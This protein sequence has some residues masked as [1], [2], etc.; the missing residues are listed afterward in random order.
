MHLW[1]RVYRIRKTK[2]LKQQDVEAAAGLPVTALSRIEKGVREI[3]A[4]EVVHLAEAL[5]VPVHALLGGPPAPDMSSALLQATL[6]SSVEAR[7]DMI[8]LLRSMADALEASLPKAAAPPP[9]DPEPPAPQQPGRPGGRAVAQSLAFAAC[10]IGCEPM[11]LLSLALAVGTFLLD[12]WLPL[13]AVVG[14]PYLLAIVLASSTLPRRSVVELA[15]A[16]TVLTT[17]GCMGSAPG[18]APLWMDLLNRTL[19]LGT[20]WGTVWC[21]Y[22]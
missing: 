10:A 11:A 16:C 18:P 19:T 12:L 3:T 15:L 13:G 9:Q 4:E 20:L 8:R 21:L 6:T 5:Q 1:E 14:I 2:G 17:L 22:V 7:E